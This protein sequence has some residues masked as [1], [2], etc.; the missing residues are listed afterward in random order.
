MAIQ[1]S[2]QAPWQLGSRQTC[3]GMLPRV[4]G[5]IR[6]SCAR[7]NAPTL[8]RT[9]A[10]DWTT[11]SSSSCVVWPSGA[12]FAARR[13]RIEQEDQP[14]AVGPVVG[15]ADAAPPPLPAVWDRRTRRR[16]QAQAAGP[17]PVA[18]RRLVAPVSVAL[19]LSSA[20][21]TALTAAAPLVAPVSVAPGPTPA[22]APAA[23][24]AAA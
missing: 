9:N 17:G 12:S 15:P 23:A 5:R 1:F 18:A 8:L 13:R 7:P 24:P 10:V 22:D 2:L 19:G 3:Q 11:I 16:M 21:A 20:V 14:S 6:R 4:R